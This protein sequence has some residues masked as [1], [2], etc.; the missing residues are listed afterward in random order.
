M[1]LNLD[2]SSDIAFLEAVKSI[3]DNFLKL[4]KVNN[5]DVAYWTWVATN[6][7]LVNAIKHGNKGN[8]KLSVKLS[9][10]FADNT[11]ILKISDKGK[12]FEVEKVKDPTKPENLLKPSG[13]GL[14]F[15]KNIM[16]SV[17]FQ[18]DNSW[19]TIILKKGVRSA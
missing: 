19:F 12:G 5:E 9:I 18:K 6:E 17:E 4:A 8:D 14:L 2:F 7:G 13:R 15:M 16:D 11:L 10:E 3:F 1:R